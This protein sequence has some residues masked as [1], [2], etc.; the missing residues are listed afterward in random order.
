[1]RINADSMYCGAIKRG[2]ILL[3][4]NG[5]N[6]E[7]SVIALQDDILNQS[8]PTL[9]GALI[10]A[11]RKGEEI[12]IN[13][14]ILKKDETGLDKDG[15]CFLHKIVTVDRRR[16]FAKKGELKKE[17]LQQ[18]YQALDVTLGRFRD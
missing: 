9:I 2:D 12:F 1:M 16:V 7:Q 18:L 3:C 17:K 5:K 8:L 10:T 4:L 11:H 14:V 15:V 13:E 6:E